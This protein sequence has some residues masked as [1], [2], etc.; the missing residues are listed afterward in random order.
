MS[1]SFDCS[2]P[3]STVHL[4]TNDSDDV[5]DYFSSI[6]YDKHSDSIIS[7]TKALEI[8]SKKSKSRAPG[9]VDVSSLKSTFTEKLKKIQQNFHSNVQ[10]FTKIYENRPN[11]TIKTPEKHKNQKTR[12]NQIQRPLISKEEAEIREKIS[13][14]NLNRINLIKKK[15]EDHKNQIIDQKRDDLQKV[16]RGKMFELN[17]RLQQAEWK[18]SS[19]NREE[20]ERI[21]SLFEDAYK[22]ALSKE[23]VLLEKDIDEHYAEQFAEKRKRVK[24][25]AGL[26]DVRSKLQGE[27]SK[28]LLASQQQWRL[29]GLQPELKLKAQLA[30]ENEQD[31]LLHQARLRAK[32]SSTQSS[33]QRLELFKL[34]LNLQLQ[35]SKKPPNA[36]PPQV[37]DPLTLQ[38]WQEEAQRELKQDQATELSSQYKSALTPALIKEVTRTLSL[39]I[40]NK[41][42]KNEQM[43]IF[44]EVS[45]ELTTTFEFFKRETESLLKRESLQI[46]QDFASELKNLVLAK[47][48]AKLVLKEKELHMKYV[49][50]YEKVK[51]GLKKE[52]EEKFLVEVKVRSM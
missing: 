26:A 15:Y 29:E 13:I 2:T 22:A 34:N 14:L 10:I 39:S 42:F 8:Q 18:K 7:T 9:L 43:K 46:E 4:E 5:S 35:S 21:R 24:S 41:V 45:E 16:W 28:R 52:T 40:E 23:R 19:E 33:S 32:D 12:E 3:M 31:L 47:A 48:N 27:Q 51:E 30:L 11:F 36:L 44:S 1:N 25:R 49:K 50:S 6:F 20:K 37:P 17:G 38:L